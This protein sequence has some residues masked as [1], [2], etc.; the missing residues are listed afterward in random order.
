MA[1]AS[2]LIGSFLVDSLHLHPVVPFDVA[3]LVLAVGAGIIYTTWGENYGEA[4]GV[5][6][7][8]TQFSLALHTIRTGEVHSI[9][10]GGG[11][12]GL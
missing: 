8:V 9:L 7:L 3:V 5:G 10:G 4:D 2:G 11:E 6:G 12:I 1:I